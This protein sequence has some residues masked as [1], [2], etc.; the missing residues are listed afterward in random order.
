MDEGKLRTIK[1]VYRLPDGTVMVFDAKGEQ[2]AE[3]QGQYQEVKERILR[4]V[5]PDAL[6]G[7]LL[8]AGPE[9]RR[10]PREQW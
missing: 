5:P 8:N 4:D 9:L 7:Y 10:I 6:F 3:Y 1:T 2:I